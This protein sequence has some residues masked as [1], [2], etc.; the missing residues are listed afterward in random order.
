MADA[1]YWALDRASDELVSALR[2]QRSRHF[3]GGNE[4]DVRLRCQHAF[5]EICLQAGQH[6]RH[7]NDDR[8]ADGHRGH[9]EIGL[10]TPFLEKPQCSDPLKWPPA[11]HDDRPGNIRALA[12]TPSLRGTVASCAYPRPSFPTAC[13]RPPHELS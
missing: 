13:C 10:Q 6:R 9:D 11:L 1:L 7:E 8:Y 3:V 5:Q 12:L 4:L 2:T